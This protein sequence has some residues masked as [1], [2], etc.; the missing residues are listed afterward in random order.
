[1]CDALPLSFSCHEN[2]IHDGA[3][4]TEMLVSYEGYIRICQICPSLT[5]IFDHS[6]PKA[7]RH[8]Y[9]SH[10]F[11][12]PQ[13]STDITPATPIYSTTKQFLHIDTT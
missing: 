5:C 4:I 9:N 11:T 3:F 10:E 6:H 2:D 12:I 1:M 13:A 7:S 8:G